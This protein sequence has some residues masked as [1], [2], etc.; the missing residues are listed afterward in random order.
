[1]PTPPSGISVPAVPA[2]PTPDSPPDND[3]TVGIPTTFSLATGEADAQPAAR[4][5][6]KGVMVSI[7]LGLVGVC[8]AI[9]FMMTRTDGEPEVRGA[10]EPPLKL[11]RR[12][13][14]TH[15]V[16]PEPEARPPE[17]KSE[18]P[19]P[20]VP[21]PEV[22]APEIPTEATAVKAVKTVK[23]SRKRP[24]LPRAAATP[25]KKP[26]LPPK[27]PKPPK[28]TRVNPTKINRGD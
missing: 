4:P 6:R 2:T 21:K 9:A 8:A 24:R 23:T 5:L 20:E 19:K 12:P 26:E 25:V 22:T 28:P 15:D 17:V 3:V 13:E 18:D 1:L 27:P 10:A 16:P 14:P 7:G 11:D